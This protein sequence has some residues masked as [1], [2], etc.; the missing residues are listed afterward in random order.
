MAMFENESIAVSSLASTSIND[1]VFTPISKKY[2]YVLVLN[3]TLQYIVLASLIFIANYWRVEPF[4]ALKFQIFVVLI[5]YV[6]L[7]STLSILEFKKRKYALRTHDISFKQGVLTNSLTTVPLSRIQH[8][9]ITQ[10][11]LSRFFGLANLKLFTAGADGSDMVIKGLLLAEAEKLKEHLTAQI[12][13][14]I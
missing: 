10:G 13:E 4:I 6:F 11:I 2:L 12:N 7:H 1:I 14:R 5:L 3:N 8:L 9:D